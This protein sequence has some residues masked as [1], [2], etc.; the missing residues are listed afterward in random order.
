MDKI[1]LFGFIDPFKLYVLP[2]PRQTLQWRIAPPKLHEA[3]TLSEFLLIEEQS[4]WT[5][6]DIMSEPDGCKGSIY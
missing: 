3:G 4:V 1:D 5:L 6:V 2:P